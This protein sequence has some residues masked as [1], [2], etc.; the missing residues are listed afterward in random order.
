MLVDIEVRKRKEEK[1]KTGYFKC[2]MPGC[3]FEG[4]YI[5]MMFHRKSQH[6]EEKIDEIIFEEDRAKKLQRDTIKRFFLNRLISQ[7]TKYFEPAK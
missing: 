6:F 4:K 3:E 1:K 7:T 2:L 5:N